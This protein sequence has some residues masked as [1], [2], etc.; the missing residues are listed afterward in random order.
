VQYAG[1]FNGD[2]VDD[3]I[4]GAPFTSG[5]GKET[6]VGTAFVI[7][8]GE[9]LSRLKTTLVLSRVLGVAFGTG[10]AH[11]SLPFLF[12]KSSS[13]AILIASV[14]ILAYRYRFQM[15]EN[16]VKFSRIGLSEDGE[17]REEEEEN[18]NDILLSDN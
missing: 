11:R 17:G 8:G 5:T 3:F 13:L 9:R 4:V 14:I 12:T 16:D 10:H 7:Y 6:Y 1:D 2:D 18:D 15:D